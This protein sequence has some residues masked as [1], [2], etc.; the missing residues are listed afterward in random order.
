MLRQSPGFMKVAYT[1]HVMG[2]DIQILH[3]GLAWRMTRQA[4]GL[5]F[6]I[7]NCK[8]GD[9]SSGQ[10]KATCQSGVKRMHISVRVY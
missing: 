7:G 8:R 10:S 2:N 3:V 5:T 9:L 1:K 4:F 6:D